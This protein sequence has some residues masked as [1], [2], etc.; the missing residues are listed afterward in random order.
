[1]ALTVRQGSDVRVGI[2]LGAAVR[3]DGTASA[4]LDLRVRHAVALLRA[5]R[6]DLLCLTGG[7]GAHGPAEAEV[8]ASLARSLGLPDAVLVV[9]ATSGTT[10]A[11]IA[12]ALPLLPPDAVL[13]LVSSRWHLPRAW[14]IARLMGRRV[15]LSGPFGTMGRT[16][17]M[18]A[19]LREIAATPLSVL[20][21]FRWRR[22]RRASCRLRQ[23]PEP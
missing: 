11:N 19:I 12:R 9:E 4:T 2:V 6:L 15:E 20:R 23:P 8:A 18:A 1:M 7:I 22:R 3:P 17:T 21:A 13:T 5:D 14:V 16:R 10:C